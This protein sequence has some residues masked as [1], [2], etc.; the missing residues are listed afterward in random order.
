[1]T[2]VSGSAAAPT[3]AT[4]ADHTVGG[5]RVRLWRQAS[6]LTR[7]ITVWKRL[8]KRPGPRTIRGDVRRDLERR[9]RKPPALVLPRG[10]AL[11]FFDK[12]GGRAIAEEFVCLRSQGAHARRRRFPARGRLLR[13]S[14][15]PRSSPRP[16][17]PSHGAF[18]A[19]CSCFVTSAE[20]GSSAAVQ[21][22]PRAWTSRTA[23]AIRRPRIWIAVI[24]SVS[25]MV[26]TVITL[27]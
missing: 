20:D 8:D 7:R 18:A 23:A 13:S 16:R 6:Q 10:D 14:R 3:R 25:A 22:P 26:W 1:M 27:R 11:E 12:F 19:G 24:S 15:G 21:P 4:A 9:R 17:D 2:Q 5:H